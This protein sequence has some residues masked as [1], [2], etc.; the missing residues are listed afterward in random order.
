MASTLVFRCLLSLF[1]LSLATN[2][3][4]QYDLGVDPKELLADFP[5]ELE[6]L[7]HFYTNYS[8]EGEL[9][10]ESF[11]P[12]SKVYTP[13]RVA[14]GGLQVRSDEMFRLSGSQGGV[15]TLLIATPQRFHFF[16]KSPVTGKFFVRAHG[17]SYRPEGYPP[18]YFFRYGGYEAGSAVDATKEKPAYN[19]KIIRAAVSRE[20]GEDLVT[21]EVSDVIDKEFRRE[22]ITYYRDRHWALKDFFRWS[23]YP[24]YQNY[25]WERKHVDYEGESNGFPIM[26]KLVHE[27][28]TAPF[29]TVLVD[30]QQVYDPGVETGY[31][32]HTL[33][34]DHFT[35]GPPD[36]SVFDPAPILKEIGGLGK[37]PKPW[38]RVW[39]LGLNAMF[40][41]W[42]GLFCWRRSRQQDQLP[43]TP[44]SPSP[45]PP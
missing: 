43:P 5:K 35:P 16:E 6:L 23:T 24:D 21:V 7:L 11:D 34:V 26:K 4:A 37:P 2:S 33:T 44:A 17:G 18:E 10:Y 19:A 1:I 22:S 28:G 42:L 38:W 14:R 41:I 30:H 40:L 32:R 12:A 25:L 31:R 20:N 29:G 3:L 13:Y 36:L 39:F 9:V 27:T 45:A 8:S 15:D